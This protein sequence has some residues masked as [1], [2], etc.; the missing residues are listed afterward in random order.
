MND[1]GALTLS[2]VTGSR[3]YQVLEY[4]TEEVRETL[5]MAADGSTVRVWLEPLSSRGDAWRAVGVEG[6]VDTTQQISRLV[7]QSAKL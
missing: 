2:E 5:A 1:H 7:T 6:G 3:T 4:A